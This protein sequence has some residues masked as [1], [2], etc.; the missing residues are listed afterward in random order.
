MACGRRQQG[1]HEWETRVLGSRRGC[2]KQSGAVGKQ[3]ACEK[4]VLR[5]QSKTK[6][7]VV[8]VDKGKSRKKR[9]QG[10]NTWTAS[11]INSA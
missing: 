9:L 5:R 4:Q 10:G 6:K 7:H 11:T 1:P 2:G 3:D 8:R